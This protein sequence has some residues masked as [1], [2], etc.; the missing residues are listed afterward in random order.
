MTIKDRIINNLFEVYEMLIA[1]EESLLMLENSSMQG[2][3]FKSRLELCIDS[4]HNA[5]VNI[6]DELE[7]IINL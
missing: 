7:R 1:K 6:S 2:Q 5:K 3:E 4:I